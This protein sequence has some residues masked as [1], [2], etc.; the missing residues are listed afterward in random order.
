MLVR[1]VPSLVCLA[2][3]SV[4]LPLRFVYCLH[5]KQYFAKVEENTW[6]SLDDIKKSYQGLH[7]RKLLRKPEVEE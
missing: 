3:L 6:E 2:Y 5:Q 7:V 4:S 1:A